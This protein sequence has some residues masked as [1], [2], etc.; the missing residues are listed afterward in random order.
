MKTTS[1]FILA[2]TSGIL[3]STGWYEWGSGLILLIGFV[4][5]LLLEDD[6]TRQGQV[7]KNTIV[8]LFTSLAILIWNLITTWWIK[9]ASITGLIA[10]VLASTFFMSFPVMIY[11]IIKRHMGRKIGYVAFILCWLAFEFAYNH[12]E[13]SWPWLTLGNGFMFSRKL[14]QWYEYTG[15]F[16]GSLWVLVSNVLIYEIIRQMLAGKKLL[17]ELRLLIPLTIIVILPILLSLFIY[18]NYKEKNNPHEIVVVQPNIDPYLKF[19]DLPPVEQTKIQIGL[20]A[21]YLTLHTDYVVCPET[22]IVD[23]IWIGQFDFVPDL[24]MVKEFVN[25][26]PRINY[27]VGIMC[28]QQYTAGNKTRTASRIGNSNL[29]YD[30]FNSAVQ[31]DTTSYVP[32]YHKSKLVIGVEK[33]PYPQYLKFLKSLTLRLGGTFR[34]LAIQ[35]ER[36]VFTSVKDGT[37]IAPVICYESVYGEFVGDY[38]KKGAN[39]IFVITNDGWWGNTPGHRQH[40]A[41]SSLRAIET[42]R[43]IARSANTGISSFINQKGDVIMS[44]PYWYRDAL[45]GKINANEKITFYVS[46]GDYIGRISFFGTLLL[47]AGIII[48]KLSEKVRK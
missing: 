12:G 45:N 34:S 4:P 13:I 47:L 10:A 38:I 36:E 1:R 32:I 29:F 24:R 5:L 19:N 21:R 39:Y 33:M 7:R 14:I 48:I 18:K 40:H 23:N 6:L 43:S 30:T 41:I 37:K 22:S 42:R 15:I 25:N 17:G 11:S 9:N 20:A 31:F 16:G 8:F 27:V 2:A 35:P 3:L 46:H 44:L 28:R 26:H